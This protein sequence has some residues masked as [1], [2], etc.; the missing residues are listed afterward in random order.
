MSAFYY[1][2]LADG[3]RVA[4]T[5]GEAERIS[6]YERE[7]EEIRAGYNR[8]LWDESKGLYRD[9][10]PFVTSV[11][12]GDWLPTDTRIETHS[13]QNNV[14][15]VLYDLA[16][17]NRQAPIVRR[18]LSGDLN[19]QPYFMHFVFDAIDHAGLFDEF[20]SAQL[21]RWKIETD[22]QSFR[23]MWGTGDYSHGWQC[24]P[25]YQM[26]ARVL[27]VT[28]SSPGFK[29]F[30][31]RP[32]ACDLTWA[33]GR[34]PTPHGDISVSWKRSSKDFEVTASVPLS[35]SA[36]LDLRGLGEGSLEVDGRSRSLAG[37]ELGSGFHRIRL[38]SNGRE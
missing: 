32:Q 19:T 36:S 25:L 23:E 2:A 33:K 18:L 30:Q 20:G 6:K 7:R 38:F 21:R 3:I 10:K 4:R 9:G 5:A 22:T 24:T 26:S 17:K 35:T 27:G 11:K 28:P 13:T 31:I 1:R 37:V 16:P 15:A 34:V 29:T 14:L 12:P 8:E